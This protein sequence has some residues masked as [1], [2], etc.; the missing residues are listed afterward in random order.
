MNNI[1]KN[2]KAVGPIGAVMLFGMFL[3][4]Y[5]VWGANWVSGVGTRAVA[6]GN[7]VG[8]EAFFYLNLN[9]WIFLIMVLGMMGWAYYGGQQ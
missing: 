2:K 7:M 9:L 3:I 5:F 6:N 1:T 8:L 4:I